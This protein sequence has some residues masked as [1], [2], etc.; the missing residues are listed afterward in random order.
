M[1]KGSLCVQLWVI[2]EQAQMGLI[3]FLAVKHPDLLKTRLRTQDAYSPIVLPCLV[4][5]LWNMHMVCLEQR[6]LS[7]VVVLAVEMHPGRDSREKV[8]F[9]WDL[10]HGRWWQ[11]WRHGKRGPRDPRELLARGMDRG[12]WVLGGRWGLWVKYSSTAS[13]ASSSSLPPKSKLEPC[14]LPS[15]KNAKKK[16][17]RSKIVMLEKVDRMFRPDQNTNL[18]ISWCQFA[19]TSGIAT[20]PMLLYNNFTNRGPHKGVM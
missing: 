7:A 19:T 11:Q 20:G 9:S 1:A 2:P 14:F 17:K 16:K 6:W 8:G 18:I 10:Q 12:L 13:A 15:L 3:H 4:A 5:I